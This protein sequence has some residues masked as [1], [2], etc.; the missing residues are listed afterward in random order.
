MTVV[1]GYVP[2][3]EG[4]AALDAAVEEVRLT[5]ERLVVCACRVGDRSAPGAEEDLA[6]VEAR[7]SRESV[8][9]EVRRA[10]AG[11]AP[12]D[13][14]LDA[15]TSTGA[16]LVVI[17]LRRHTVIGRLIAGTT[18]QQIVLDAPCDV[19]AVKAPIR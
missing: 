16:R 19:L 14:L 4:R 5:G 10:P 8:A 3:P 2:R 7:L 9:H 11:R 15:V 13:E 1:V 12:A 17:G 6:A 18:A